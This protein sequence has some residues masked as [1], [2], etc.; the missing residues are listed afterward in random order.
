MSTT[1]QPTTAYGIAIGDRVAYSRT[2]LQSTGQL[3]GD[4]PHARGKVTE[5]KGLGGDPAAITLAT[6][7]WER[8]FDMPE[9][10]NVLNLVRVTEARGVE[11]KA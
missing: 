8:K 2:F 7:V 1:K 9:R 3:T 5:L 6:I 10:V 4:A 11:D